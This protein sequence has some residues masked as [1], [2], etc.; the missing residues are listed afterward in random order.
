LIYITTENYSANKK[1][2]MTRCPLTGRIV[3]PLQLGD[4][5]AFCYETPETGKICFTDVAFPE[6]DN[7]PASEKQ[8]L[9]GISRN[10]TIRKEKPEP[11]TAAFLRTLM[12]QN[13]PYSFDAKARH[14]LKYLY[15]NGGKEYK[16]FDIDSKMIAP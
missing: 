14:F 13:I 11:F 8:I 7:L 1:P 9:A 15:D 2:T 4:Q 5:M 16:S 12:Q 6:A 3:N 10:R